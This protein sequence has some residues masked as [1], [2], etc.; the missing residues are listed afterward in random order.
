MAKKE[1]KEKRNVRLFFTLCY[2]GRQKIGEKDGET[3][4]KTKNKKKG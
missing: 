3:K 1:W 2:I 4:K